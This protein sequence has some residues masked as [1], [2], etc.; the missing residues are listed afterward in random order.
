MI[1]PGQVTTALQYHN[2]ASRMKG[3]RLNSSYTIILPYLWGRLL[4]LLGLR[5]Y[6][7]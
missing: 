6:L 5:P 7:F 4:L 2:N 1:K 3:F